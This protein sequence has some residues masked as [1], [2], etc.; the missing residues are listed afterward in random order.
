MSADEG[1]IVFER[2]VGELLNSREPEYI[3]VQ[4]G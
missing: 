3:L 2:R 4:V 1:H